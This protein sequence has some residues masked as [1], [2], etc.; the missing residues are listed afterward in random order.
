MCKDEKKKKQTLLK[1]TMISLTMHRKYEI[2][3]GNSIIFLFFLNQYLC[4][5]QTSPI[6]GDGIKASYF[7]FESM[8]KSLLS[9]VIA[10]MV[11]VQKKLFYKKYF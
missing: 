2:T 8:P 1:F 4:M 6:V 9:I 7:R 10:F 3:T 5:R 11:V